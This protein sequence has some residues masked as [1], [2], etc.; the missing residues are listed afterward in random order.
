MN[1]KSKS[2]SKQSPV[3]L[4]SMQFGGI[5]TTLRLRDLSNLVDSLSIPV[6]FVFDTFH[7]GRYPYGTDIK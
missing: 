7:V 6:V 4:P 1:Y 2:E 5:Q 3:F